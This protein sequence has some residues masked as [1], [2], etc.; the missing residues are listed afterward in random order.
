MA[1]YKGLKIGMQ[2]FTLRG[3]DLPGVIERVKELDIEYLELGKKHCN[4]DDDDARNAAMRLCAD[5]GITINCTGVAP[6]GGK[7]DVNRMWFEHAKAL[8]LDVLNCNPQPD[9]FDA[10]DKLVDEYDINVAIHNHGPGSLWPDIATIDAA[11]KDHDPRI[12]LCV[13]S[14]HFLRVPEDPIAVMNHFKDRVHSYHLKDIDVDIGG[15]HGQEYIVGEGPLDL[16]AVLDL[17]REWN[18]Q[19]PVSI[20]YELNK[21]A[22]MDDLRKTMANI[23]AALG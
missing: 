21:D 19:G 23:G 14:G 16:K 12:G 8:G 6:F 18:F 2:S 4:P 10:L 9:C 3:F 17:L 7:E 20:E 11:I 5:N 22:P 13:D 15:T 1:D